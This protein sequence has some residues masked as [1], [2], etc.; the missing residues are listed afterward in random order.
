MEVLGVERRLIVEALLRP[1][2]SEVFFDEVGAV[3]H[4]ERGRHEREECA[5][6]GVIQETDGNAIPRLHAL[7]FAKPDL[8]DRSGEGLE[9]EEQTKFARAHDGECVREGLFVDAAGCE[10]NRFAHVRDCTDEVLVLHV[11]SVDLVGVRP[12]FHREF[13]GRRVETFGEEREAGTFRLSQDLP[14]LLVGEFDLLEV[15]PSGVAVHHQAV[16]LEE[17]ELDSISSHSEG[18]VEH[19]ERLICRSLVRG[20]D[21]G[22]HKTRKGGA[23]FA[24]SDAD[25]CGIHGCVASLAVWTR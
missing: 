24:R 6:V 21:L 5:A 17:L 9:A 14:P 2:E 19:L 20:G 10:E 18:R 22:E 3:S 12:R 15:L 11:G 16:G 25:R 8:L 7:E 13:E 1:V 23:D 4:G